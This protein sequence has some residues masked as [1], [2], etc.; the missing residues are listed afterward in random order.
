MADQMNFMANNL[1]LIRWTG[2]WNTG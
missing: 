2:N 1:T